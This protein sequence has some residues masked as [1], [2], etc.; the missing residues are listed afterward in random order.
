VSGNG[1]DS[2]LGVQKLAA[3]TAQN[4]HGLIM[5]CYS[6]GSYFL[7]FKKGLKWFWIV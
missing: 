1:V 4:D 7:I 6:G 3:G 5:I 2:L